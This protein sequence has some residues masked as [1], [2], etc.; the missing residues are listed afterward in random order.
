MSVFSITF[1]HPPKE[2]R[3]ICSSSALATGAS[4]VTVLVSSSL[5]YL[6]FLTSHIPHND[7][8]HLLMRLQELIFPKYNITLSD[9]HCYLILL[10]EDCFCEGYWEYN[11]NIAKSIQES[12]S[13]FLQGI[14]NV[15]RDILRQLEILSTFKPTFIRLCK[16]TGLDYGQKPRQRISHPT[17]CTTK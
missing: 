1:R 13:L 2:T 5:Q 6:P 10:Q 16:S 11:S 12:I 7:E 9:N 14:E 8:A 4:T 3:H 15:I 17:R